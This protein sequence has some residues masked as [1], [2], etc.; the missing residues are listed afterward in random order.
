MTGRETD[1]TEQAMQW[2]AL[3]T[4][5]AFDRDRRRT[6]EAW[7]A[8]SPD[9]AAAYAEAEA[10]WARLAW[11]PSLNSKSL[12]QPIAAAEVPPARVRAR[13]VGTSTLVRWGAIAAGLVLACLTPL[14]VERLNAGRELVTEVGE[15]RHL[16]LSDGSRASLAGATRMTS[17]MTDHVRAVRLAEGDAYFDV[18]HDTG[19]VFTVRMDGLKAEAVGT[20][21][22]VRKTPAGPQVLV[23]EG[24]VRVSA[25]GAGQVLMAGPGE[26]VT[27]VGHALRRSRFDLASAAPWRRQRLVFVNAPFADVV[28]ELNRYYAPGVVVASPALDGRRVT[29]SFAVD[30]TP[31]AIESMTQ[32]MGARLERVPGKADVVR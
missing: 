4:G 24:R 3:R 8:E 23:S 6:F 19:R 20:A 31:Q 5:G 14:A 17:L 16:T 32:E 10:L 21:F 27:L 2:L 30:Q 1:V 12:E 15:I 26:R 9:H 18:A 28:A 22:E 7:R 13:R 25:R 11:S 29:A